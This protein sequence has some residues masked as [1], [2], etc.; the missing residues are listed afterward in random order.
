[1]GAGAVALMVL[2][3]AGPT[4]VAAGVLGSVGA[5]LGN[6]L[7]I[8]AGV[9]LAVAAVLIVVCRRSHHAACC[10]PKNSTAARSTGQDPE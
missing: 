1:M 4:L 3:C 6:P 10:P 9:L 5:F 7:V 8:A 2:C